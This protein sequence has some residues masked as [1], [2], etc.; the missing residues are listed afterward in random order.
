MNP[1]P[2]PEPYYSADEPE[3]RWRDLGRD[4]DAGRRGPRETL[5]LM[6]ELSMAEFVGSGALEW[7]DVRQ[8]ALVQLQELTALRER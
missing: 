5:R 3:E 2:E 7:L 4:L 6:A 1:Q 8:R